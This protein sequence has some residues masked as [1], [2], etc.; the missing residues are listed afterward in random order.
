MAVTGEVMGQI[1]THFPS[2]FI[3]I[4]VIA[5]L[6]LLEN[7]KLGNLDVAYAKSAVSLLLP[8]V[9]LSKNTAADFV[10]RLSLLRG[11]MVEFMREYGNNGAGKDIVFDGTSMLS[12]ARDNPYCGKGYS[13]GNIGATQ[14][15]LIYAFDAGKHEPVYFLAVPGN[16]ADKAAFVTAFEELRARSCL[17]I[18]D[19]GFFSD[20]NIRFILGEDGMRFI[21]PL[22]SNTKQV[23]HCV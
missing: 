4:Y 5:I 9:H 13:P 21:I 1:R 15:R 17:L 6:K 18:L 16:I 12:N 11:N 3:R 8:E 22:N 2:D 7:A 10:S 23:I 19:K 20:R 14:I